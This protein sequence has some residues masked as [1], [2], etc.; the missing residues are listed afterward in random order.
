M[1]TKQKVAAPMPMQFQLKK[2]GTFTAPLAG[3]GNP[4]RCGTSTNVNFAYE[5]KIRVNTSSLD[6]NDFVMDHN[7]I[8]AYFNALMSKRTVIPSCEMLALQALRHF[9][10][11][12][13]TK[14]QYIEV[15]IVADTVNHN[16]VWDREIH[17]YAPIV[18]ASKSF[19]K[20]LSEIVREQGAA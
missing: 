6:D 18:P 17:K 5:V 8:Q 7:Q 14:M 10:D 2:K 12:L 11:M 20:G 16:V 1:S 15:D 4:G 3:A 19:A 9:Y 13:P